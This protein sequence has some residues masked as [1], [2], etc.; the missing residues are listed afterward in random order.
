MEH[1][2]TEI[3]GQS[4]TPQTTIRREAPEPD[5]TRAA[6]VTFWADTV[7][8]ARNFWTAR[9]FKRMRQD[10]AF[11]AGRQWPSMADDH[12]VDEAQQRYVAN[13][14]LRHIQSRTAAI[15]GKNP[16]VVARRKER[17]LST[18]WDGQI[19]TFQ[20]AMLAAQQDP[21]DPNAQAIIADAT[22]TLAMNQQMNRIAKTLQLLFEHEIAEQAL[23]FKVQMK[24]LVRRCLTTG[25]GYAKP[26]YQRAMA[27]P[28]D[29]T[30]QI[31]DYRRQLANLER[32]AAD[33]ADGEVDAHAREREQ[34]RL[35]LEALSRAEQ[36]VIREGLTVSYPDSWSIIPDTGM[37][38]LRGFVGCDWVAEEY[39]LPA[40]KIKE[41]YKLDVKHGGATAYAEKAP[42]EFEATESRPTDA[43]TGGDTA[44][45]QREFFCVWEIYNK[46]D[47]MV[48]TVLDGHKDFL[49][50]PSE[51]D[52]KLER[53]WPWF[54]FVVNEVYDEERVFPP[55]D[56]ELMRNMQLELNRARQGLREHRRANRP[57]YFTRAGAMEDGDKEKVA[58][59]K[60]HEVIELVG[61]QPGEKIEDVIQ[62]KPQIPIDPRLY[63]P[64]PAYED[65]L[66][67]L[68]QH[69]ASLGGTSGAT[70]TESSI[71]EGARL[72]HVSSA[73]DDLDE[74]LTEFCRAAGQI[75]LQEA[76]PE[77]VHEVV[78]PGAVWPEMTKEQIAK[79]IYLDVEA[80]S[81]GRPNQAQQVQTAQQVFPLLMQIPG[82]SPQWMAEELLRR[83]DDRIDLTDAFAAGLPSIMTMNRAA[84]VAPPE[85]TATGNDPRAQGDHGGANAPSTQPA[86]VNAAPRPDA[87]R[88]QMPAA[89]AF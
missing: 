44:G 52:V 74:F 23:P 88:A 10:M 61:I 47:G 18:V 49:L 1:E 77:R 48:Y 46:S 51:P 39:F 45:R 41:I 78:G 83:L 19:Q 59:G 36:V 11:A 15:Y 53:F 65:Y 86:Q 42:G 24:A 34:L 28:P 20:A 80:A 66:R 38:Q 70:A 85:A 35:A 8:N 27:Y 30:G 12:M 3:V 13:I 63:D 62:P 79:E 43:Q 89:G 50:P 68:G 67:T 29:V 9:A 87:G 60:A 37:K 17:L 84:Q 58:Q 31:D 69:E 75:L 56:V 32:L 26:G 40:N 25:V 73:V 4:Q 14:T 6:L 22:Q 2:M 21:M 57:Q 82:L 71:A 72:S 7:R 16:R 5:E 54:T 55:S 33:V 81:T 76:Q 64:T